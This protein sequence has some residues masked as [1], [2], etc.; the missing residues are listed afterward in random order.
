MD[1]LVG[2]SVSDNTG[3]SPYLPYDIT[4]ETTSEHAFSLSI[5]YSQQVLFPK[6]ILHEFLH[7]MK[8]KLQKPNWKKYPNA[9]HALLWCL[10][11]VTVNITIR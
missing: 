6:G 5:T 3:S 9:K 10:K 11:N 1:F 4:K 7:Y 8:C 2:S